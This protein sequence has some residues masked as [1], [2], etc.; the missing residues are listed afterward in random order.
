[1]YCSG[2]A[3]KQRNRVPSPGVCPGWLRVTLPGWIEEESHEDVEKGS[4]RV[5]GGRGAD[6]D[7][8]VQR[9]PGQQGCGDGADRLSR[10]VG[11]F[12]F[13]RVDLGRDKAYHIHKCHS[14][15]VRQNHG[16]LC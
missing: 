5:G 15:G 1:M 3:R 14:P 4:D 10:D 13:D 12:G 7:C 9:Q 6:R 2:R 8:G 11:R 16:N